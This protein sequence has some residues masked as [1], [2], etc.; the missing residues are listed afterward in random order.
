MHYSIK[1][2]AKDI[3]HNRKSE[4]AN[5]EQYITDQN[6][7][8][9]DLLRKH[10]ILHITFLHYDLIR[11]LPSVSNEIELNKTQHNLAAEFVKKHNHW[12]GVVVKG[13]ST[14]K[15]YRFPHGRMIGDLDILTSKSNAIDFYEHL[16]EN[17]N[18]TD[19]RM[20]KIDKLMNQHEM[21]TLR[22]SNGLLVDLNFKAAYRG[23][24][25]YRELFSIDAIEKYFEDKLLSCS[26]LSYSLGSPHIDLVY[27]C[28]HYGCEVYLFEFEENERGI[29]DI[30]LSKLLDV[31]LYL[32]QISSELDLFVKTI[33]QASAS[34]IC[35]YLLNIIDDIFDL[36]EAAI[37]IDMLNIKPD[38]HAN[39]YMSLQGNIKIWPEPPNIR[40]EAP[41][42]RSLL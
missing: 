15:L 7:D 12:N 23:T 31:A 13:C 19:E 3:L 20:E 28:V 24:E 22:T 21:P 14:A 37:V 36:K 16:R 27:L 25:K 26:G 42:Q 33:Q 2:I 5:I 4:K 6:S 17:G 18:H 40:I 29:P 41:F 30:R 11:Y 32:I 39:T 35:A 38:E 8:I 34:Q 1:K 10:K 9:V